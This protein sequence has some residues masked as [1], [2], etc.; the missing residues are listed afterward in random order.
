MVRDAI[1]S[2]NM[3]TMVGPINFAGSPI[4][5]VAVTEVAGGQ[6]RKTN[7]G[8]HAFDLVITENGLINMTEGAPKEVEE[9]EDFMNS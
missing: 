2:L 7:G 5:N 9:I 6:W 4:K 3:Q 8:K 1:A